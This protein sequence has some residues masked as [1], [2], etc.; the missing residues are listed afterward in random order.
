MSTVEKGPGALT[1]SGGQPD[2]VGFGSLNLDEIW[3]VSPSFLREFGLVPGEEYVRDVDWFDFTYPRL[4]EHGTRQAADPGGSAANTIAALRRMGFGTGYIGSTGRDDAEAMGLDRLG[5]PADLRIAFHDMPAG[6]CLSL[7]SREDI[8][9][10]R[11]LVILP[12]ANDRAGREAIDPDY[13]SNCRD[14]HL[15]S[16]VS[17]APLEAQIRLIGELP[18]SITVSFDPGVVYAAK[19]REALEPILK[20]CDLL[21][22]SEEELL[23]ITGEAD[24]VSAVKS[25][26]ERSSRVVVVKKGAHGLDAYHQND[27]IRQPAIPP[28][29]LR[30]RTGAGDVAAA[31]FIAGGLLGLELPQRLYVAALSASR[32]IEGY[33][34]SAYPDRD[35]L[36]NAIARCTD[37]S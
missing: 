31:G 16:F 24:T 35:F 33:G 19:G 18:D 23:T 8:Q 12:N 34:R 13:F 9:R 30:D 7:I 10:D 3:E 29:V 36:L 20:R 25:F 6:R 11:A 14:V 27:I 21:F 37:G 4:T 26:P 1:V 2:I 5:E 22:V 32:S 28:V 15:T 17:S